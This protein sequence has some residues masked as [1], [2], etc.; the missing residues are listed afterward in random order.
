MKNSGSGPALYL[1]GVATES[2]FSRDF[3]S[4]L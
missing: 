2:G 4:D 3:R 1:S